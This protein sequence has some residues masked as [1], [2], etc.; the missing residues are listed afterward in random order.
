MEQDKRGLLL[1]TLAVISPITGQFRAIKGRSKTDPSKDVSFIVFFCSYYLSES[2][3]V[4]GCSSFIANRSAQTPWEPVQRKV[5]TNV[6]FGRGRGFCSSQRRA[7]GSAVGGQVRSLLQQIKGNCRRGSQSKQTRPPR[8]FIVCL[9]PVDDDDDVV[10][11]SRPIWA[12]GRGKE[13]RERESAGERE[14]ERRPRKG[15]KKK[16]SPTRSE[17]T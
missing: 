17:L 6:S 16:K 14:R 7:V 4:S 11:G 15:K 13:K 3:S 5:E 2:T 1:L 9:F 10:R 8:I 12:R